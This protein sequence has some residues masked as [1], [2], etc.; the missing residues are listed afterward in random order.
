MCRRRAQLPVADLFMH[1]YTKLS[2]V[3]RDLGVSRLTAAKYL[4]SLAAKGFVHKMKVGRSDY[5]LNVA[6]GTILTRPRLVG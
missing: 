4:D 3:E 5:F 1:P 6:L 2:F